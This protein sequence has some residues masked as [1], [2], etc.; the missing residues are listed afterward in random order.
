MDVVQLQQHQEEDN[1]A[2][3]WEQ[4]DLICHME[5]VVGKLE[6]GEGKVMSNLSSLAS[7]V[8]NSTCLTI[9]GV[10][11]VGWWPSWGTTP[12]ETW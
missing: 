6:Q 2:C 12:V 11:G 4:E 10:R 7:L 3:A 5:L 9:T 1:P 8:M